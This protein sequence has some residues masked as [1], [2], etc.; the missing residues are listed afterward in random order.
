MGSRD[1]QRK[2]PKKPKQPKKADPNFAAGYGVRSN[3]TWKVL[4]MVG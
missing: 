3:L 4:S 2:E 1:R